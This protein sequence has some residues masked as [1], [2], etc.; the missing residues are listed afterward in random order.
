[1]NPVLFVNAII[2][3]SENLFLV[4]CLQI[5]GSVKRGDRTLMGRSRPNFSPKLE[6]IQRTDVRN[7]KNILLELSHLLHMLLLLLDTGE[8][9]CHRV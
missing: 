8:F 7:L 5:F 9:R 1:M 4:I 2:G 3:F 6:P